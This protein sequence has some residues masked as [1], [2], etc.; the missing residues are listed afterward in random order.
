MKEIKYDSMSGTR[1]DDMSEMRRDGMIERK[2]CMVSVIIPAYNE[3]KYVRE[4]LDS[5]FEGSADDIDF[6]VIFVDDNSNDRTRNLVRACYGVNPRLRMLD[7]GGQGVSHAR[8]MALAEARGRYI[9]FCDADDR[10][11]KG[12]LSALVR[13]AE[14]TNADLVIGRMENFGTFGS[15]TVKA[16]DCLAATG[17]GEKT[18]GKAKK[19]SEDGDKDEI[20]QKY[21]NG[22]AICPNHP[23]LYRTVMIT[24]KLYRKSM[25]EE[26]GIQ[27]LPIAYAEDA[28]FY[29]ECVFASRKT[30]GCTGSEKKQSPPI[31]YEYRKRTFMES[32]SVTQQLRPALWDDFDASNR[33][34]EN[35]IRKNLSAEE[36]DAYLDGYYER[37][38][39]NIVRSF[40]RKYWSL[41][42]DT[43]DK[44]EETLK[45]YRTKMSRESWQRAVF[46]G[47]EYAYLGLGNLLDMRPYRVLH[48]GKQRAKNRPQNYAAGTRT[49]S[50]DAEIRTDSCSGEDRT[51]KFPAKKE[52]VSVRFGV[53]VLIRKAMTY[54]ELSFTLESLYRQDFPSFCVIMEH[55]EKNLPEKFREMENIYTP[56]DQVEA[57]FVLPL[58]EP[59]GM[60]NTALSNLVRGMLER[61]KADILFANTRDR[62]GEGVFYRI[63]NRIRWYLPEKIRKQRWL[64]FAGDHVYDYSDTL[65]R[66][67]AYRKYCKEGIWPKGK[68]LQDRRAIF[69]DYDN[70]FEKSANAK[71]QICVQRNLGERIYEKL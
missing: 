28:A 20:A 53:A 62:N 7:G 4:A 48:H 19:F 44:I 23:L 11:G 9:V 71:K 21:T 58:T 29:M 56:E 42:V 60:I 10:L 27:F 43:R 64:P 52:T 1:R 66:E 46:P 38:C 67:D 37:V 18:G 69:I 12:A 31:I 6:E 49:D 34:V 16:A 63:R 3:E 33:Y 32:P 14:E 47:R 68:A 54:G 8:N 5:I 55:P 13:R 24:G 61:P 65:W 51:D 40:W 45:E 36:L 41:S 39:E 22:D 50:S 57:D 15:Y 26:H 17:T 25:L 59:L 2:E 35:L 70:R 30:V